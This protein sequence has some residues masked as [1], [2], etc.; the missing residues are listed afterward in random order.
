MKT[1]E[2]QQG[3]E[4]SWDVKTKQKIN[5]KKNGGRKK[6]STGHSDGVLDSNANHLLGT[7]GK[8]ILSQS[9]KELCFC[10]QRLP[11]K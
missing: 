5:Y 8:A 2:G 3:G 1:L 4:V 9:G 10:A 7:R 6:D 11:E